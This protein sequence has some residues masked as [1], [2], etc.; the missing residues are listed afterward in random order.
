[1]GHAVA[2]VCKRFSLSKAE[3]AAGLFHGLAGGV[4]GIYHACVERLFFRNS[5]L[6]ISRGPFVLSRFPLVVFCFF[7]SIEY[8]FGNIRWRQDNVRLWAVEKD[9]RRT[10]AR[11]QFFA[12]LQLRYN[13]ICLV[14]NIFTG[15]F[16]LVAS[17]VCKSAKFHS[18]C[19]EI[20]P[21]SA[22]FVLQ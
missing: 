22:K 12:T 7:L 17:L 2:S 9:S 15:F 8:R 20:W 16:F 11:L 1:M 14:S 10:D 4:L 5:Y 3:N 21:S 13:K 18:I 19:L 6:Y